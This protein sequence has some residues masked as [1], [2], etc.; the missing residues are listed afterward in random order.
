VSH[1]A[2]PP[3]SVSVA[4]H[5][6]LPSVVDTER[7]GAANS[8]CVDRHVAGTIAA[9]G[10]A[11]EMQQLLIDVTAGHSRTDSNRCSVRRGWTAVH[12]QPLS[13]V[14]SGAW[15]PSAGAVIPGGWNVMPG[16]GGGG[17]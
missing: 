8:A 17:F 9:T 4:T 12:E 14:D 7:N 1:N 2:Q 5:P 3:Y 16:G 15:A 13:R 11:R 10:S 6:P